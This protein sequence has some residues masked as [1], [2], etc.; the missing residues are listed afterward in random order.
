MDN[1]DYS[2]RGIQ[3]INN[4]QRVKHLQTDRVEAKVR[5]K[6]AHSMQNTN[7]SICCVFLKKN[8]GSNFFIVQYC[9]DVPQAQLNIFFIRF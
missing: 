6:L 1:D 3:T 2:N 5:K 9:T 8:C 4:S 7:C